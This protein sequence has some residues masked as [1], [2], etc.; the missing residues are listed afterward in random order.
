MATTAMADAGMA[1]S[2]ALKFE[3]PI[4]LITRPPKLIV[5]ESY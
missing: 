3:N 4:A 2:M 1:I 5:E